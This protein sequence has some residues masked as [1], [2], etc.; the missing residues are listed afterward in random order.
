MY[1]N[2]QSTAHMVFSLELDI[3]PVHMYQPICDVSF[4]GDECLSDLLK[5]MYECLL[6]I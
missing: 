6:Y 4:T 1:L 3:T 5:I 2:N